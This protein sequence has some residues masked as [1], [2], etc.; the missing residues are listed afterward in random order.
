MPAFRPRRSVLYMPGSNSRALQKARELPA[1]CLIFDLEDAVA[2]EAK[3]TA[4]SL[5][6]ATIRAGGYGQ[7]ELIVRTNGVGTEWF[8]G[9]AAAIASCEADAILLPKIEAADQLSEARRQLNK[10]GASADLPFWIMAETPR[11]VLDLDAILAGCPEVQV[12]VMGTSDLAKELRIPHTPDRSGLVNTLSLCQLTARAHGL[13]IIDGVQ[14][15]LD[16]TEGFRLAC[17][18]GRAL[19]FDGKS[20]IHPRQIAA[21]NELFGVSAA[22]A[23]A[24]R[25]IVQAWETART[26]GHG[27]TVLNDRLIEQL[28]VEEAERTLAIHAATK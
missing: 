27:I 28:H 5:V 24:A 21:A 8:A 18:Q 19:G 7:R 10:A 22:A 9:D 17:Q 15:A 1:D 2:P 26:A 20:L 3:D 4:A 13:D 23:A 6:A 12:V 16:D 11:G 25:E 14:L